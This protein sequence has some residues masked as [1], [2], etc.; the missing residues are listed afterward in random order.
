MHL[1][2]TGFPYQRGSNTYIVGYAGDFD[3]NRIPNPFKTS[4]TFVREILSPSATPRVVVRLPHLRPLPRRPYR[5][6][7][8]RTRSW[9]EHRLALNLFPRADLREKSH[10]KGPVGQLTSPLIRGAFDASSHTYNSR[11]KASMPFILVST[12]PLATVYPYG[13]L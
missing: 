7:G 2:D 3:A 9:Q 5:H 6:M 1:T 11:L 10:R 8:Y 12:A 4:R 13:H